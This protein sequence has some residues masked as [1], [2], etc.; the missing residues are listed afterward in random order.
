MFIHR[1]QLSLSEL[2]KQDHGE[3]GTRLDFPKN[4]ERRAAKEAAESDLNS[5]ANVTSCR[6]S[7]V[8]RSKEGRNEGTVVRRK[9]AFTAQHYL[10]TRA[11]I[12]KMPISE[13]VPSC[14]GISPITFLPI[15]CDGIE[16]QLIITPT[17]CDTQVDGVSLREFF[18]APSS[19][20]HVEHH[21]LIRSKQRLFI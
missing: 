20:H 7:I 10:G 15:N 13:S 9:E 14:V 11:V 1:M 17:S 16:S 3:F 2:S 18:L 21:E 5:I 4:T 12:V 8:R 19:I 6:G